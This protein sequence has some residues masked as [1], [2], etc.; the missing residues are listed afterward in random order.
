M[1]HFFAVVDVWLQMPAGT[2]SFRVPAVFFGAL[3]SVAQGHSHKVYPYRTVGDVYGR[4]RRLQEPTALNTAVATP[5]QPPAKQI[6]N[7]S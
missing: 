1:K 6:A 2:L 7:C 5:L 4:R 3:P